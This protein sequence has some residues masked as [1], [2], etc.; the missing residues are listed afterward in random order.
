MYAN[1][2]CPLNFERKGKSVILNAI[3]VIVSELLCPQFIER[4]SDFFVL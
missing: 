1:E 2:K 3:V 4:S